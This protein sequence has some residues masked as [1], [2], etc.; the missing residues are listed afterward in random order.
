MKIVPVKP[1]FLGLLVA[2]A[3]VAAILAV[4]PAAAQSLIDGYWNPLLNQDG[5]AYGG[6]P[7]TGDFAGMPITPA[8]VRV[9]H[10]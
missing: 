5:Y 9:A 8:G 1:A 10:T 4:R 6:G 2:C 7:D 3:G